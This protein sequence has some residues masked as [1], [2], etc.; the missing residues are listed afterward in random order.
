[1]LRAPFI[2]SFIA[3]DWESKNLNHPQTRCAPFIRSFIANEWESNNINHPG[4]V[5][6]S[7]AVSSRMS[8]NAKISTTPKPSPKLGLFFFPRP[9]LSL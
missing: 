6:H 3:N 9:P 8:G 1:M 5:P 2:R 4:R 7:F